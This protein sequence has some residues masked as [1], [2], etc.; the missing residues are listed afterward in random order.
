[1]KS[2]VDLIDFFFLL[3]LSRSKEPRS[4]TRVSVLRFFCFPSRA[5]SFTLQRGLNDGKEREAG[6]PNSTSKA[7]IYF[8]MAVSTHV[9][10][11]CNSA[12]P[13][14][15][16]ASIQALTLKMARPYQPSDDPIIEV[17][18]VNIAGGYLSSLDP[19]SHPGRKYVELH[20]VNT[21]PCENS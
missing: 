21:L 16:R 17:N 6:L 3:L 1:M 18:H 20:H 11:C 7:L 14:R 2:E 13:T 12:S 4:G 19:L 9:C 5:L 10:H 15:S 8:E